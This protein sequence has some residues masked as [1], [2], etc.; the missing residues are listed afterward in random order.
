MSKFLDAIEGRI[1]NRR[2]RDEWGWPKELDVS[3]KTYPVP[4]YLEPQLSYR[5]DVT[6]GVD[7]YCNEKAFPHVIKMVK[8]RLRR[9]IYGDL[10]DLLFELD[11]A[12]YEHDSAA[13]MDVIQKIRKET[14]GTN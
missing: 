7:G 6:W 2:R 14:T 3:I 4:Y 1:L 10:D 5:V 12:V 13:A 11:K 9:A 8:E